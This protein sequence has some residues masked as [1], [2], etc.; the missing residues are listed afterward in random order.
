[1]RI[2]IDTSAILAVLLNEPHRQKIIN[3]TRGTELYAPTS[4]HWEITN[5]FTAM[6]KQ[7]RLSLEQ[8]QAA[9]QGYR[10]IPLRL[11]EIDLS[12]ALKLSWELSI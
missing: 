9:L 12:N 3:L 5:A 7:N 1:M 11:E 8:A 6:F 4:L 10:R 2:V